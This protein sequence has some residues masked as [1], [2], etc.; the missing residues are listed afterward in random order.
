[1]SALLAVCLTAVL[2]AVPAEAAWSGSSASGYAG[3]SGTQD[4]PYLISTPEQLARFRDEVNDG[5]TTI[6]A[7]L[8]N[9]VDMG[10]IPWDPIG[11]SASGYNGT[12]NG[13]GYAVRHLNISCG[14]SGTSSGG[15]TLYGVGFFGIVG[16]SGVVR[17]VNVDGS[18][19]MESSGWFDIGCIAG[20][21]L[22]VIEECFATVDFSRFNLAVDY[23][24]SGHTNF[25]GLV[26]V[27]SGTIR[28]CY[29][30]GNVN[31]TVTYTDSANKNINIGGLVGINIDSDAV[32][33]NCYVCAEV[34]PNLIN[35]DPDRTHSGG[36]VGDLSS[37]VNASA[38]YVN[39]SRCPVLTGDGNDLNAELISDAAMKTSEFAAKLGSAFGPDTAGSNQGYPILRVM[40]Y[41]EEQGQ[42]AWVSDEVKSPEDQK[43]FQ[44]LTPP[45]LKG[46]DLSRTIN[47]AE[48]CAVA[49]SLYEAMGGER[50]LASGLSVPFTDI[51]S[52]AIAKAYHVGITNGVSD[53]LFAP[54]DNISREQMSVMLTRVY[55]ALVLDNWTLATDSTYILDMQASAPFTDDASI[56]GYARSSV[57]FMAA[58]NVIKG[59]EDGSFRPNNS[60]DAQSAVGYANATREQA[61]IVAV[62]MYKHLG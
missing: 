30:I 4:D 7:S 42:S 24:G 56:S 3:G 36:A 27:N 46:K 23:T 10:D 28:N 2:L 21:N 58:N 57:Y 20:G 59:F 29:V 34:S 45:E 5:N 51:S 35:G 52:D 37:S 17:H 31:P 12:F 22:G 14:S 19:S 13:N 32:M 49:V 50:L 11:L 47:R 39:S 15:Y 18:F 60:T 44:E 16:S 61:I 41:E 38:L 26:G 6:C 1:M 25:G 33:E 43:L 8:T 40:A 54:Y 48:F 55:K 53:T 62:R 9:N